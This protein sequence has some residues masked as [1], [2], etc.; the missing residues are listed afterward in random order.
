VAADA[1]GATAEAVSPARSIEAAARRAAARWRR[2]V[3]ADL[4]RRLPGRT[5]LT[6]VLRM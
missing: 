5:D 3:L 1:A 2:H 4:P 6:A